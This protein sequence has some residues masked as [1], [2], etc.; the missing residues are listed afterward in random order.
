MKITL[1]NN[2]EQIERDKITVNELLELKKYTFKML[3]VKINN[4]IVKK[5]DYA[6]AAIK[7]GDDVLVLHLMS[8]G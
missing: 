2:E 4:N 6:V 1:N 7:D 8:G 5:D 3:V